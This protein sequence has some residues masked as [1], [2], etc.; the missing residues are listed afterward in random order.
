MQLLDWLAGPQRIVLD[1]PPVAHPGIGAILRRYAKLDPD[2]TDA[3]IVWLA[4]ETG[5]DAILTLNVRDFG[6]YR[7]KR[8]KRFDLVKWAS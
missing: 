5:C 1:L 2:F 4:N 8:N 6:I 3:A 7:L